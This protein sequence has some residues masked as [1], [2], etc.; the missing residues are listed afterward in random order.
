MNLQSL[1]N[2]L[3]IGR[4]IAVPLFVAL[5][6]WGGPWGDPLAALVLCGAHSAD[7]VMIKGKW[8]VENGMPVG[9]DMERLRHGHGAVAKMFL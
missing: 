3:T 4:I 9:I 7:R 2:T 6:Y 1:P 8:T 5:F